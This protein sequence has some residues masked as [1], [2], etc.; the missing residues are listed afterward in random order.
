MPDRILIGDVPVATDQIDGDHF[1]W[2]KIAWGLEDVWTPVADVTGKRLPVTGIVSLSGALPGGSNSLG[3]VGVTS[4]PSLPAGNNNV[5]DF[6]VAT[7]PGSDFTTDAVVT[8]DDV[9]TLGQGLT[10]LTVK[11]VPI[12]VTS[13]N[14]NATLIAAVSG[15]RIMILHA[16]L[17]ASAAGK[18][19]IQDGAGGTSIIGGAPVDA[20]SGYNTGYDPKGVGIGTANTIVNLNTSVSM[21]VGG[22]LTYVEV[23]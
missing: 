12:E 4:L 20:R 22:F 17:V 6:D 3:S 15:K 8:R 9:S 10:T 19:K 11:R 16:M 1:Q 2:M 7:M 5:G 13:L 14:G 23:T 21:D 18:I